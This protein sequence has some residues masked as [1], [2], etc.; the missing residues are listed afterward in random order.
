MQHVKIPVVLTT[1]ETEKT[2]GVIEP[3]KVSLVAFLSF[4]NCS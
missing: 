1:D 4:S 2:I 3:A